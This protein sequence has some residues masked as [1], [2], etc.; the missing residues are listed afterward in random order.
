MANRYKK[1]G[2]QSTAT[3]ERSYTDIHRDRYY[4][5]P[6]YAERYEI[7]KANSREIERASRRAP[8]GTT[9]EGPKHVPPPR[10]VPLPREVAKRIARERAMQ[11]VA[12]IVHIAGRMI[13]PVT[14][15]YGWYDAFSPIFDPAIKEFFGEPIDH[16]GYGASNSPGGVAWSGPAAQYY[17]GGLKCHVPMAINTVGNFA[18]HNNANSCGLTGQASPTGEMNFTPGTVYAIG[19][20]T[21]RTIVFSRGYYISGTV[22][23]RQYSSIFWTPVIPGSVPNPHSTVRPFDKILTPSA[24]S[25]PNPNWLRAMPSPPGWA[26]EHR[27]PEAVGQGDS[28]TMPAPHVSYSIYGGGPRPPRV[29]IGAPGPTAPPK[30]GVKERKALGAMR[31]VLRVLDAISEGAEVV[32][33]FYEALPAKTRKKWDCGGSRGLIDNAG[34]YG[35]DKADCKLR[36]LWHNWHKVD[37][38]TAARNVVANQLQDR[39]IGDLSR[40]Q[41]KNVGRATEDG[42]KLVND[43]LEAIFEESGLTR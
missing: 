17:T 27:A 14:K 26:G 9:F 11:R 40:L 18:G 22:F 13:N 5:E 1:N 25:M 3:K 28:A 30:P 7:R 42:Q 43:L 8:P 16:P 19:A 21:A 29:V 38:E 23:R 33:A 41:P 31:T 34:Q 15:A 20:N 10:H 37:I 35:I 12:Q 32:D 24:F 39:V 6:G 36:A 4:N 2:A